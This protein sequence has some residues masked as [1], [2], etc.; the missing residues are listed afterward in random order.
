MSDSSAFG[1]KLLHPLTTS[2]IAASVAAEC[3][4]EEGEVIIYG[5]PFIGHFRLESHENF[6]E[7]LKAIGK[8]TTLFPINSF[9]SD[10]FIEFDFMMLI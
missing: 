10:Y 5:A 3:D 2:D 8:T 9:S 4:K 1:L 7:F 6:D